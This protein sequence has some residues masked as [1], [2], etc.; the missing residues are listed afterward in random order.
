[1][2]SDSRPSQPYS[3]FLD[4]EALQ[5]GL[6]N[7]D[8]AIVDVRFRLGDPEAG[9]AAYRSSHVPGA[10]YAHLDRDLS[11]PIRPGQTGRHPLPSVT[12]LAS[13]LSAWGIDEHT[14]VVAYDDVGGAF[15][16]R[17]WWQ[18]RQLGHEAVAVL[19]GGWQAWTTAGGRTSSGEEQRASRIFTPRPLVDRIV[20]ADAVMAAL[21]AGGRVLDARGADRY[22]GENESIDPVAGHIPGAGNLPFAGNLGSD[23]YVLPPAQL[24]ARFRSTLEGTSAEDLIVYCGSG[25]TAAHNL[26]A[27]VH[28]GLPLAR[29]YAGSWSE[30]ITD[31]ARPV[32]VGAAP[33]HMDPDSGEHPG[34]RTSS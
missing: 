31:P 26:L 19:D 33:G 25:V 16:A 12:D 8:W 11:G 4:V 9:G 34:N 17:L 30:W 21:Q 2:P 18:L 7:P 24:E 29:L 5:S 15:A 20:D 14:Q 32:A 22:R 28:A 6:D 23:G 1:M 10:V 27:M 13:T 3:S